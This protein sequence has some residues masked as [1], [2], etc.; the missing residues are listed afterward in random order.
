MTAEWIDGDPRGV[1]A[2][3]DQNRASMALDHSGA[4][5]YL[6]R[7]NWH[8]AKAKDD[9]PTLKFLRIKEETA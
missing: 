6:A 3:T 2:F 7:N 1:K 4:P 8:L 5:V 9:F